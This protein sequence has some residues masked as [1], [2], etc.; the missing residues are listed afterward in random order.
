MTARETEARERLL[1][2]LTELRATADKLRDGTLAMPYEE[3]AGLV[4]D[5]MHAEAGVMGEC[6]PFVNLISAAI[7]REGTPGA[8]I[9]IGK[10]PRTGELK[11]RLDTSGHAFKIAD[12]LTT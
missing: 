6:E 12:R 1:A 7:T 8:D 9:S 2:D 4:A 11:M 5:W 3:L 10:D